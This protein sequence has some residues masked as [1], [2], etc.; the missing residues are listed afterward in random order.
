[1][2]LEN[3]AVSTEFSR[4]KKKEK[5]DEKGGRRFED[6]FIFP[7][8]LGTCVTRFKTAGTSVPRN[9]ARSV[10]GTMNPNISFG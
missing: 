9:S 4:Y 5:G 6:P 1:M 7:E 3:S 8:V 2:Y 10:S